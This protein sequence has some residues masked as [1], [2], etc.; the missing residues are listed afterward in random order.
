[1][2]P[3]SDNHLKRLFGEIHRRGL[4][5][6]LVGFA[7]VSYAVL[8]ALDLFIERLGLP[9]WLFVTGLLLVFAGFPILLATAFFQQGGPASGRSS[10]GIPSKAP[11]LR[12][13]RRVFTWRNAMLGGVGASA[14]W[15]VFAAGWMLYAGARGGT[16]DRITAQVVELSNARLWDSAF[17]LATGGLS[18]SPEY[19]AAWGLTSRPVDIYTEPAGASARG[20]SRFLIIG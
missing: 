16:M 3:S 6:V 13:A 15:G 10:G 11:S 18:D 19:E 5:Q 20:I 4:W 1:M 2:A 14:L 17:V 9:A 8:D 12:F 7:A